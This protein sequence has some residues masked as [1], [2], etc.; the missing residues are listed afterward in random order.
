MTAAIDRL[1]DLAEEIV[2]AG[3][4]PENDGTGRYQEVEKELSEALRDLAKEPLPQV[5][6]NVSGGIAE[7]TVTY[8]RVDV[9]EIDWDNLNEE[10]DYDTL[11]EAREEIEQVAQPAYRDRLLAAIDELIEAH[12]DYEAPTLGLID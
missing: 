4:H 9:I 11:L 7:T 5:Y 10:E 1:I 3:W 8:G 2:G 6:V 12:P